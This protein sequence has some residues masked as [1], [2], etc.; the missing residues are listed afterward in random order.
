VPLVRTIV[1]SALYFVFVLLLV[2]FVVDLVMSL[3]PGFR[4]RG[5]VV[6]LL[7]LTYTVTDPPLRALRRVIPPLPVGNISI[8]LSFIVLIIVVQVLIQVAQRRL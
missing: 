6:V 3:R 7:E 2:R 4:P 1:V 8:D 5:A